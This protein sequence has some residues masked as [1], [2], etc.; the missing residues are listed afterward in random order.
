MELAERV[1]LAERSA[2]GLGGETSVGIDPAGET[3][4]TQ[5]VCPVKPR[6]STDFTGESTG[7]ASK[8]EVPPGWN[9]RHPKSHRSLDKHGKRTAGVAEKA[10]GDGQQKS[11]GNH[12]NGST[13]DFL[14]ARAC[15]RHRDTR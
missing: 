1:G 14:H 10:T 11:G 12:G 6:S 15:G 8:T 2:S 13:V 7:E 3:S 4:V 5:W 9:G